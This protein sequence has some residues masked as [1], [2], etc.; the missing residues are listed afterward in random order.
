VPGDEPTF[1]RMSDAD[2]AEL[3][4]AIEVELYSRGWRPQRSWSKQEQA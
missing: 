4:Q 1:D 3:L 2:L